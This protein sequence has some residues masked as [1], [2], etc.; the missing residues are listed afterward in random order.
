[1]GIDVLEWEKYQKNTATGQPRPLLV[2]AISYVSQKN[3]AMDFGAGALNDTQFFL[4]SGFKEVIALDITPQFKEIV[5]PNGTNFVYVEKAFD[6]YEF[7][8]TYFDIISA[9]YSLPFMSDSV[10]LKVW[11]RL[12]IGLKNGGIFTGQLF[13][14]RDDWAQREGMTFYG[15]DDIKK[16]INGLEVIVCKEQEF[17][18]EIARKKHWH[19]FDLIVRKPH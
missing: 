13:G 1:M 10:F 11:D 3:V 7:A 6:Q 18:E 9:Q 16:L 2:E 19:Y 12:R 8:P 5:V 17:T 15:E 4:E 14:L